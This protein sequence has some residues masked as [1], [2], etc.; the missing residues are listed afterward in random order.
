MCLCGCDED[1][2][3]ISLHVQQCWQFGSVLYPRVGTG[4]VCCCATLTLF[5]VSGSWIALHSLSYLQGPF[6]E[7]HSIYAILTLLSL[8]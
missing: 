5:G 8:M 6:M 1:S 4:N 7:A 2:T 3:Y